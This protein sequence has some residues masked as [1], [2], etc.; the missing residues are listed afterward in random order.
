MIQLYPASLENKTEILIESNYVNTLI[1]SNVIMP[2]TIMKILANVTLSQIMPC[3]SY[4]P[5]MVNQNGIHAE[6]T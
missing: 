6:S 5:S 4:P 3:Y 2:F 1:G